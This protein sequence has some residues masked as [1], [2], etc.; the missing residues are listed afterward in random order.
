MD[1]NGNDNASGGGSSLGGGVDL[2]KSPGPGAGVELGRRGLPK[3]REIIIRN[4]EDSEC[5]PSDDIPELDFVYADADSL[6]REVSELYSFTELPEFA[7]NQQHYSDAVSELGLDVRWPDMSE[8]QRTAVLL[9]LVDKV[10]LARRDDRLRASRAILYISQGCWGD[11]H[12][13]EEVQSWAR[14]NALLLYKC[15][16]LPVLIDI[17]NLEI[18]SGTAPVTAV[19][20]LAVS[21]ADSSDLRV[22]LSVLY[23]MVEQMR[24]V[25]DSDPPEEV[26]LRDAF[27]QELGQPQDTGELLAV[28][29]LGMVSRFCSGAAPHFPMKKVLLLTWKV[30]LLTLGG[31]D[32]LRRLRTAARAAAGLPD[33]P[34]DTVERTRTMRASSPPPAPVEQLVDA[35]FGPQRPRFTRS[36]VV[37]GDA[38]DAMNDSTDV[39]EEGGKST[40]T[41]SGQPGQPDRSP[42]RCDSP[43]PETPVHH[44]RAL[45]WKPKVHRRDIEEYLTVSRKKFVGFRLEDD[46]ESMAGLPQPILEGRYILDKHL[47]RSLAEVQVEREEEISASPFSRPEQEV[48][49]TPAELLFAGMLPNLPQYMIALLKVLLAAAPTSKTK[50]DSINILADTLPEEMP[51]SVLHSMK[52]GI[53]V[54]R[55]KE[56]IAKAVSAVLLLLLKH[57]KLNHVYQFEFVSQHLVFANCIPLVLKFFNQDTVQYVTAKNSISALDFP[58]CVLGPQVDLTSETLQLGD[59]QPYCWRNVF[60]SINLLRILNKLCKWKHSRIMMLVVFKSAPILKRSLRVKHAMMQVYTLK[61]LKMQTKYLGRQWRKSNMRTVSAIYSK[62]RHRL[63]DDWAFGNDLKSPGFYA[64]CKEVDARPWDYEAEERALRSKVDHFIARRYSPESLEELE[65][66]DVS[67]SSVLATPLELTPAFKANYR[68]WLEREVF[69]QSTDWDKLIEP[70]YMG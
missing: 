67:L 26:R 25:R 8:A 20:K 16:V 19:R 12:T 39:A 57:L 15:G 37:N 52:L 33:V 10:E 14:R 63:V 62:V 2:A 41:G 6:E 32:Q 68:R 55:Q 34:E 47:Y 56:V 35:V 23:L 27:T 38:M 51:V 58:R 5:G 60:T 59:E 30:L 21:V 36:K 61:L 28:S 24:H 11:L 70:G 3:L 31:S 50:S 48:P 22:L 44:G 49:Q 29:L 65:P 4:R 46:L 53:D 9:S 13:P 42:P 18:E 40:E 64:Y 43:R 1:T 69:Q 66:V 17:L 54:N 45:P 7:L